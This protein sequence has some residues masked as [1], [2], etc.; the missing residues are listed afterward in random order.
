MHYSIFPTASQ[1]KNTFV[2]LRGDPNFVTTA[3]GAVKAQ[4]F[5]KKPT[6]Q[7]DIK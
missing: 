2:G 5:A 3:G 1:H 7:R 6:K 4:Q